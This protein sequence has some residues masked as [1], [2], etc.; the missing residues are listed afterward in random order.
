MFDVPVGLSDHSG[1]INTILA[2][3]TMGADLIEFHVTFHK[4]SF[5]PDTKSSIPL[6]EIKKLV[7]GVRFINMVVSNPVNKNRTSKNLVTLKKVF[8][9]SLAFN[10][11]LKKDTKI[12][13]HHLETKK[14]YGKG[15][16]CSNYEKVIGKILREDV[17]KGIF[18]KTNLFKNE[19]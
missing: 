5:G 18:I 1:N 13:I 10:S 19:K 4:K 8:G 12:S 17:K 3:S 2:A 15:I 11:N 14:P 9:K 16:P 7:D 6:D